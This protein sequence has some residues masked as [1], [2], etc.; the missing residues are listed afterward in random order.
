MLEAGGGA[1][2]CSIC[3]VDVSSKPRAKDA[4][5]RYVCQ[6]CFNKAK[7]TKV[8]QQ[9]PPTPK[10]AAGA[11]GT[12]EGD[13]DNAF[14]LGI[15]SKHSVAESGTKPC[16]EC[17]R[18]LTSDAAICVGCGFDFAKGKR[19]QVKVLKARIVDETGQPVK[20][21][22]AKGAGGG[23]NPHVVGVGTLVVLIGLAAT[24]MFVPEVLL[25]YSVI[26]AVFS[27]AIYLTIVVKAFQDTSTD[28]ILCL[29]CG[30]YQIYWVFAKSESTLL[31]WLWCV[32]FV[33]FFA[34]GAL[35]PEVLK[36]FGG[37]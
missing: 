25:A 21:K 35:N 36:Q 8:V 31:K 20:G 18:A 7:Q 1:K 17:G 15:G 30:L 28:G 9:T 19:M 6:D 10:A 12:P 29:L 5:G 34:S 27:I 13:A 14:L 22:A 33:N 11:P 32:N 24:G 4:K 3:G 2:T 37:P 16:P 26:S 23:M